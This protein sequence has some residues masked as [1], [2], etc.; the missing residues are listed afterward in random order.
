MAACRIPI[1]VPIG[2]RC[3]SH[4]PSLS[5]GLAGAIGCWQDRSLVF[6][7]W[8]FPTFGRADRRP[9][10]ARL[11]FLFKPSASTSSFNF[12]P[13]S[14]HNTQHITHLQSRPSPLPLLPLLLPL[15]PF[16]LIYLAGLSLYPCSLQLSSI[17]CNFPQRAV[18]WSYATGESP[19]FTK[20]L[21]TFVLARS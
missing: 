13:T 21:H 10:D 17:P 7:H 5:D 20:L 1:P 3:S 2:W 12:L 15:Q 6:I 16:P 14:T 4:P 11:L 9:T 8:Y 19:T 18:K